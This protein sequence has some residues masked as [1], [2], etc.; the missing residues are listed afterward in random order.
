MLRNELHFVSLVGNARRH[1]PVQ[2]IA[3]TLDELAPDDVEVSV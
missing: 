3:N 2:A 1:S